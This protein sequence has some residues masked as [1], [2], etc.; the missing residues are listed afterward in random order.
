MADHREPP[1]T[2]GRA[3]RGVSGGPGGGRSATGVMDDAIG[4]GGLSPALVVAEA[5]GAAPGLA[6]L[7]CGLGDRRDGYCRSVINTT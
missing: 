1:M 5:D 3:P 4:S 2:H 6:S 7:T